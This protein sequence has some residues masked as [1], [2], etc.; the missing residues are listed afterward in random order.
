MTPL[1]KI[2]VGGAV[3]VVLT[4]FIFGATSYFCTPPEMRNVVKHLR[5]C[6][7]KNEVYAEEYIIIEPDDITKHAVLPVYNRPQQNQSELR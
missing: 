4:A 1:E 2:V 6:E 3:A 5:K 7:Q